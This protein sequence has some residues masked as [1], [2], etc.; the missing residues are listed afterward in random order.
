M[1]VLTA[2][3]S[4]LVSSE[5]FPS[6]ETEVNALQ[7]DFPWLIKGLDA[8]AKLHPFIFGE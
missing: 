8:V 5:A 1:S 3:Y 4:E 6:L 7:D 2:I